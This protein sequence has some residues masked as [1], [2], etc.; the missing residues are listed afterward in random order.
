[1]EFVALGYSAIQA[2]GLRR[3]NAVAS[4][5]AIAAGLIA[6]SQIKRFSDLSTSYAIASGHLR[7]INETHRHVLGYPELIMLVTQIEAAVSREH[8]MWLARRVI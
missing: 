7:R 6:W 2:W 5:A 4:L 8:T 3:F 1:L